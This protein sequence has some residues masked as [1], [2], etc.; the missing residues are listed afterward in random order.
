MSWESIQVAL[1]FLAC[2]GAG[3]VI[4]ALITVRSLHKVMKESME[5]VIKDPNKE[6]Q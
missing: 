6:D 3:M 5:E 2:T 4:G 1:L